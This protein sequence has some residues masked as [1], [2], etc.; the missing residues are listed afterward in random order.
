[1]RY[2]ASTSTTVA[3]FSALFDPDPGD[4]EAGYKGKIEKKQEF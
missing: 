4:K 1:L 3:L 2:A